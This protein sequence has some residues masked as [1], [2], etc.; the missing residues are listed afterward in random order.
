MRQFSPPHL[1]ALA[2]MLLTGVLGVWAARR[3]PGRWV[4]PA[5]LVLAALIFAAWAGEYL[6]D[7]I[8]GIWSVKYD[9][10]LQLTD[11]VSLVTVAALWSVARGSPRTRLV[12]LVYFWALSASLQAVLTPDLAYN[13]PSVF[14][15]TYFVYHAGAVLAALVLVFG[16]GMYPSRGAVGRVY[17]A[18][19]AWTAIAGA[20]DLITGGNYMYLR[21]KPVH[22]SLL[23]VMGPWPWY[24]VATVALALAL[25]LALSAIARGVH[26]LD[27]RGRTVGA[28]VPA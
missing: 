19:M 24:I 20:G 1:A 25:L 16:L 6:A 15:F 14:Y 2:V 17:A 12:E 9:L 23:S 13:F 28:E 26:R 3:H 4:G 27:Q 11:A 22:G 10:P 5:A 18:S 7:V 8:L 21:Y